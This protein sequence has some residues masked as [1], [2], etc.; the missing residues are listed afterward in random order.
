MGT[1]AFLAKE[2]RESWRSGR[3][4]LLSA[5]F[6][7]LGIS[8]PLML[9]FLPQM[10]PVE[11]QTLLGSLLPSGP[12]AAVDSLFKN[13]AQV[14]V[15]VLILVAMGA[16]AEERARGQLELVLSKPVSVAGIVLAKFAVHAFA[17]FLATL[18]AFLPFFAYLRILYPPGVA[19][20]PLLVG[21]G[22][23]V[24][25][26]L[27][28]IA[29]T[30]FCSALFASQVGAA[31]LSGGF[32]LAL[33]FLPNLGGDFAR[34]SPAGLLAA[35]RNLALGA[36][37]PGDGLLGVGIAVGGVVLCLCLAVVAMR[38]HEW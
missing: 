16:I 32:F 24:A 18:C 33:S 31:L 13:L 25:Y 4:F 29:F 23:F 10:L 3:L 37:R 20:L 2:W 15:L 5:L 1:R 21:A 26:G 22:F 28:V 11:W 27:L 9:K 7:V 30:L 38:N 6:L 34:L 14:G 17:F 8:T 19:F 36:G 12:V 35:A